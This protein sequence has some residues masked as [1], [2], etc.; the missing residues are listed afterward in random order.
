MPIGSVVGTNTVGRV[1]GPASVVDVDEVEVVRREPCRVVLVGATVVVVLVVA[2][3]E[4]VVASE[5]VV[6][7]SL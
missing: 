4:V 3:A 1:V 2:L 7:P 6:P 5:V